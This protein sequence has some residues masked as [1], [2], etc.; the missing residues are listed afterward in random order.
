MK[1]KMKNRNQCY[2]KSFHLFSFYFYLPPWKLFLMLLLVETIINAPCIASHPSNGNILVVGSV[3][4]DTIL[5]VPRLPLEG[6]TLTAL[7]GSVPN[8]DIPGGKGCNQAIACARLQRRSEKESEAKNVTFLGQFGNDSAGIMLRQTL[9]QNRV[10]TS[11]CGTCEAS[12]GRG[13]VFLQQSTGKVSAVVS[14][15]SNEVGWSAADGILKGE[16]IDELIEGRTVVLLQREIPEYV[17]ELV[18]VACH[19]R[20]SQG[21]KQKPTVLLDLGGEDRSISQHMMSLCDYIIPNQSELVR[22]MN[23]SNLIPQEDTS[24][25][26]QE[27]EYVIHCAKQLISN[28]ANNVLVTLGEKGSILVM[29]NGTVIHQPA[30]ILPEGACVVDE[31][32]AG[33]CFRAAFAVALS[34]G[35]NLRECLN[36]ASAA[37]AI[38]VTRKGAVPSIPTR[39]DVEQ[40]ILSN[41]GRS[42]GLDHPSLFIQGGE[43]KHASDN[44]DECPLIFGSRLNSMKDRPDLCKGLTQDVQS[45][46]KRQ[47]SIRGLGCVDFNY[48][49]HFHT[50]NTLEAKAALDDAG[51]VAGAVCL[52]YPH[53]KFQQGAMTHPDEK[54][55]REAI[56]ITKQAAQ[57]ARDLSCNEVVVWSAY[58]GYDYSFQVNYD[59][60][61]RQIVDA[62]RECC[63]EFPDINFSV[64]F[65]PTDENTRFF[66]VP[67]T[68]AAL[69]LVNEIDR[70]NM[71]LTLD[72]GH[73][74]MSGENP[75]QSIAMAG[76]KLFGVQLNDGYTRLA[77]EDGLMFGS[78]HPNMALEAIYYLQKIG[79]RGHLYFDTFPQRTDPVK[80]A[81]YNI[82]RVKEF[83]RAAKFLDRA[84]VEN[85][86]KM[87]DALAALNLADD[88][89]AFGRKGR[90]FF[91]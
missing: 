9:E 20:V 61:W 22:L 5:L 28:G 17:N 84:G 36:F 33:D 53:D 34:E 82:E 3:N 19:R 6:E 75:A 40:L 88:A 21:G 57:V 78:I 38:C 25:G 60:K 72:M 35:K 16:K 69:L 55:R 81:E 76:S 89:F 18:A 73:M 80:E 11:F 14:S 24:D 59:E 27:E 13:Y 85:A 30:C 4:A 67:S 23:S 15:G 62:F 2:L 51:R 74:L 52:R 29:R 43:F 90:A 68:G 47:G 1:P 31:T 83:W 70:P 65:K 91:P 45:W 54:I 49:Q 46:V 8:I 71:G 58:D 77:A 87:H 56:E 79:Y 48:P 64:E 41:S 66:C 37:G 44:E 86:M 63:D 39:E 12:S 10:E 50:W 26:T 7:K 32:G 42:K